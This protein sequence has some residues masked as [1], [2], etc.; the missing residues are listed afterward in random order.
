MHV[1]IATPWLQGK[2]SRHSGACVTRNVTY[3]VRGPSLQ[4]PIKFQCS[5]S[6]G[7]GA[8]IVYMRKDIGLRIDRPNVF[9]TAIEISRLG[10]NILNWLSPGRWIK[11]VKNIL[12]SVFYMKLHWD[13]SRGVKIGSGNVLVS[14]AKMPLREPMLTIIYGTV[15]CH[16]PTAS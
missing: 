3:L 9:K 13:S 5:Q 6:S 14:S 8:S 16:Q 2:R 7:A 10:A 11:T 12:S 4:H 15:C 1:G